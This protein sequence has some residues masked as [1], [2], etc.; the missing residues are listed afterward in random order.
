LFNCM[1][2]PAPLTHFFTRRH[3]WTDVQ[4][5]LPTRSYSLNRTGGPK[6]PI[7][8]EAAEID[9]TQDSKKALEPSSPLT[10]QRQID[11]RTS[12][13]SGHVGDVRDSSRASERTL[14]AGPEKKL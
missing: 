7:E 12:E 3:A 1:S 4:I 8:G 2:P 9:E 5:T 14:T 13:L 11:T 6:P 10:E